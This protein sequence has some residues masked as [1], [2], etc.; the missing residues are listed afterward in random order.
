MSTE[1]KRV[2][3]SYAWEDEEYKA[4][5]KQ[6]ATQLREHGVRARLD[7]W[8]IAAGENIPGFM[9][10]EVRHADYVLILGSP[11]Y[12]EKVHALEDGGKI[13]G[14]GWESRV[15][16][17]QLFN[18]PGFKS[19]PIL[20][21]GSWQ[22]AIPM[23]ISTDYGFDLSEA[24]SYEENFLRLVQ[25]ITGTREKAPP[26]G[27]PKVAA[28]DP[29]APVRAP[30]R[31]PVTNPALTFN[32]ATESPN[33]Y[34]VTLLRDG[35][36]LAQGAFDLDLGLD[37]SQLPPKLALVRQNNCMAEDIYHIGGELWDRLREGDIRQQVAEALAEIQKEEGRIARIQLV[38]PG[39]LQDIPWESLWDFTAKSIGTSARLSLSRA[40]GRADELPELHIPDQERG[41]LRMLV[42]IPQGSGL[43]TSAEWEKIQQI[44]RFSGQDI[45]ME[46]LV[47]EVSPNDLADK[48]QQGWDIV[49]FIGHGRLGERGSV[50]VRFN[51]EPDMPGAESEEQW[52]PAE[53]FAQMF[54]DRPPRLVVLNCCHG[55]AASEN[56]AGGLGEL[57]MQA[58]VAACVLMQYEVQDSVAAKFAGVF[59]R[60]LLNGER[61][62]RVDFAMQKGRVGLSRTYP[63]GKQIRSFITPVLYLRDNCHQLF[64]IEQVRE[65]E[66]RTGGE[67][68]PRIDPKLVAAM[69][70]GVCLPIL[71]PGVLSAG[72]HRDANPPPGPNRLFQTLAR[73]SAFPGFEEVGPLGD[74]SAAW[75]TSVL[76]ERV[77]QHFE[78]TRE[79][80]DLDD[81][82]SDTYRNLQAPE[83]FDRFGAWSVRGFVYTYIDGLLE[84]VLQKQWGSNLRVTQADE[85]N[86]PLAA[87]EDTVLVNLRG[88][89]TDPGSMILTEDDR[90]AL[91]DDKIRHIAG[92]VE[93]L[94]NKGGACTLLFI[95]VSPR[96]SLVRS[97]SRRILR[98]SVKGRRGTAYFACDG[99][100]EADMFY[101]NQMPKLKVMDVDTGALIEGLT[102]A[103]NRGRG[104]TQ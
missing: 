101:W 99:M 42:V 76:F 103:A 82:I 85:I 45:V 37:D 90:E 17:T 10:S 24:A 73:E 3:I 77:C 68:D 34:R 100:N 23:F 47:G 31:A 58:Q 25:E 35:E 30:V 94:M 67:I 95:G 54:Q 48:L 7:Q 22:E 20:A 80:F 51:A 18:Q 69:Q 32:I 87:G 55:A 50:E 75:L 29:A 21:R 104:G 83:I 19:I 13:T 53:L 40:P 96:D 4:W 72:A 6:F 49:H 41:A 74:S 9:N 16:T 5:V 36:E 28:G 102:I 84:T 56:A 15:V 79:R 39:E 66:I 71:G 60:E 59:Y 52:F 44:T 97:L 57:L 38:V 1:P 91:M 88:T 89:F 70:R 81:T 62:G 12:R 14:S 64:R 93:N 86:G 8:H 78:S 92:F 98:S 65:P 61:A 43:I 11:T 33:H 46:S 63:T 2:F 27:K 26:V